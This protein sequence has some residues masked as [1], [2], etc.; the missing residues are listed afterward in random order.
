MITCVLVAEWS[1]QASVA[2]QVRVYTL[3][4]ELPVVVFVSRFTVA[5]LQASDAVGTVKLGVAV[6][7]MVALPPA[8]P[9]VGAWVSTIVM[10]WLTVALW[11]PQELVASQLLVI[12]FEQELPTVVVLTMFTVEPPHASEAVGGLK[13]GVAVHSI[14]AFG[15]AA[16]IVGV[17]Q[18][19]STVCEQVFVGSIPGGLFTIVSVIV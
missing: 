11:F 14:V 9:I 15:P 12:T 19:T 8:C 16:P 13:L 17:G 6:Q 1:P 18:V 7:S 3:K 5:P 4:Q 2:S 10:D